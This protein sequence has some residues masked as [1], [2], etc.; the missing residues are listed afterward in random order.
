[1]NTTQLHDCAAAQ[2]DRQV[3]RETHSQPRDGIDST[4]TQMS[5]SYFRDEWRTV[6]IF[7]VADGLDRLAPR[8]FCRRGVRPRDDLELHAEVAEMPRI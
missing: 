8:S 2:P 7:D 1:M 4:M 6:R 3:E 5:C